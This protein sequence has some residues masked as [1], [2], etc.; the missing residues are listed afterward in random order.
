MATQWIMEPIYLQYMMIVVWTHDT[1]IDYPWVLIQT[2]VV[3]QDMKGLPLLYHMDHTSAAPLALPQCRTVT[4]VPLHL[5]N[6]SVRADY[7]DYVFMQ[8]GL[9]K[10]LT[11]LADKEDTVKITKR[12]PKQCYCT[13]GFIR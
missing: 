13:G 2:V 1:A 3:Y 10:S 12:A 9:M 5:D 7:A 4:A 11:W 8:C 6:Y